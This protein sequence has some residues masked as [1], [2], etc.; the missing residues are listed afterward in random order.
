MQLQQ[1]QHPEKAQPEGFQKSSS[2]IEEEDMSSSEESEEE[3]DEIVEN[4]GK[5]LESED[6]SL[7]SL[8]EQMDNHFQKPSDTDSSKSNFLPWPRP[9]V[10]QNHMLRSGLK[11]KLDNQCQL[12]QGELTEVHKALFDECSKYT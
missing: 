12:R 1:E 3:D 10:F 9:F 6:A 7:R 8:M 5:S 2:E 4:V 11:E